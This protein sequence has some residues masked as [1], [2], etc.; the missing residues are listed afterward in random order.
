MA[1]IKKISCVIRL[2][3][4]VLCFIS[5][6]WSFAQV[7]SAKDSLHIYKTLEAIYNFKFD[8]FEKSAKPLTEKEKNVWPL[9]EIFALRWKEVPVAYSKSAGKYHDLLIQNI[10]RL[11]KKRDPTPLNSYFKICTLLF[12]S[13]YHS[14]KEENWTALKYAQKA[15]PL[16]TE[17][18]KRNYDQPE[19]QF[20]KGLYLY[21]IEYYRQKNL[22]YR[23][24]LIPF[25]S[26]DRRKG[27]ELLNS[28]ADKLSM[29]QVEARIFSAHILLRIENKPN[30]ALAFSKRLVDDYPDNLKFIELY[31]D[32]LIKCK[33][34]NDAIP[35]VD[36]LENQKSLYYSVPG[37][38]FRGIIEEE[39][40]KNKT[41]AKQAYQH[42]I[43]TDYKPIEIYQR[44]ALLRLKGL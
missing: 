14:S 42:C 38:F 25:H 23:A 1:N 4:L 16:L 40:F 31:T 15:Y 34:Y 7:T 39:Y 19:F 26:G 20:I 41:T 2:S 33:M 27:F 10:A 5:S 29:A 28:S 32:N 44:L 18:F 24:A 30:E 17:A 3:S 13:E 37:H 8:D 22:F 35:F 12:L 21:Y 6:H 36:R 43:E 9:L 11:E